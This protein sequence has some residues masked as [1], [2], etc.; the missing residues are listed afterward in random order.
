VHQPQEAQTGGNV[1]CCGAVSHHTA[2]AIPGRM[3]LAQPARVEPGKG[4]RLN[5]WTDLDTSNR[6]AANPVLFW[7]EWKVEGRCHRC[8]SVKTGPRAMTGG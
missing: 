3:F 1:D 7:A 4:R 2:G 6:I 8:H 5:V